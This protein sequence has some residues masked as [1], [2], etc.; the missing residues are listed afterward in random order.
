[1]TH[2]RP[3]FLLKSL[4]H[5]ASSTKFF[6]AIISNKDWST[7][8]K[9]KSCNLLCK[10]KLSSPRP[11]FILYRVNHESFDFYSKCWICVY[12]YFI[13]SHLKTAYY[14]GAQSYQSKLQGD[15]S[16]M[17]VKEYEL[18]A[19]AKKQP[20]NWPICP[21]HHWIGTFWYLVSKKSMMIQKL[22]IFVAFGCEN[23]W[24]YAKNIEN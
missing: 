1:M 6:L 18:F 24:K 23:L 2:D 16:I 4:I 8:L 9:A 7:L 21:F 5:C 15:Q 3:K 22:F 10:S 12:F 13:P 19:L 14:D 17:T 11:H 20:I